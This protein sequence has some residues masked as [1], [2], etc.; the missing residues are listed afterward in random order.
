MNQTVQKTPRIEVVDA[1]RGFAV[2]CILLLH[3][4]EHFIFSVYPT[5]SPAWL[6]TM[7]NVTFNLAF[8]LFGGKAY[9]IFSLLFGF[10]FYVQYEN[11]RLKGRDFGPRFLWRLLL[12]AGIATVNASIFPGGD[13]LMLYAIMGVSLFVVRHWSNRALLVAAI[14]FLFQPF[15]WGRYLLTLVNPSY[16]PTDFGMG[17]MYGE[18]G[19]VIQNGTFLQFLWASAT[20]GQV[21]S[22]LWALGGGRMEQTVG[23]FIL[24][25]YIARRQLFVSSE[26]NT[27]LWIR[28]LVTCAILFSPLY[29]LKVLVMQGATSDVQQT[30]GAAIDM[31]QKLAFTFVWVSSFILLYQSEGFRCRVAALRSYGRMSLTNYVTQS[32]IGM[33][34]YFPFGLYLAPHLGYTVSLLLGIPMFLVQL[35]FCKWWLSRHKQGPLE[36]LWHKLTWIYKKD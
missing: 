18:L 20:T 1:L 10:T 6:A 19:E 24:G 14:F 11:Q 22:L 13:V 27:R 34:V 2:M 16:A 32:L 26:R 4:V 29:C 3:N 35:A 31:W 17:A 7:D 9:A 36:A 28:V 21:A 12:L 8:N 23:I 30:V 5:D 15:E 33:L 25:Y